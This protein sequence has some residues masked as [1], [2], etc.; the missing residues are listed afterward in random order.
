MTALTRQLLE[1][2]RQRRRMLTQLSFPEKVRIVEKLRD[3]SKRMAQAARSQGLRA[4]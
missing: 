3:A 1:Q 4:D 2:K